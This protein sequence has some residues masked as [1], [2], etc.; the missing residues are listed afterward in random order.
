MKFDEIMGK[1][2]EF[3]TS[4]YKEALIMVEEKAR[5]ILANDDNLDEFV[6]GMGSWCFWTKEGLDLWIDD[7]TPD[8]RYDCGGYQNGQCTLSRDKIPAFCAMMDQFEEAFD[9]RIT[10]HPMRFT[11]TGELRT[12]W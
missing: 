7:E 6:M 5:E 10:G 1:L 3:K 12:D 9:L 8:P 4:I 2:D 11:A